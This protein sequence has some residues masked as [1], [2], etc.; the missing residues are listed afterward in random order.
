MAKLGRYSADRKK[1]ETVSAAKTVSVAE[2][3]TIFMLT[4]SAAAAFEIAL[5]TPAAAG[6]GWWCKFIVGTAAAKN[7]TITGAANS[8]NAVELGALSGDAD[9]LANPGNT[10][11]IIGT[12]GVRSANQVGDQVELVTDGTAWYAL[13][14]SPVDDMITISG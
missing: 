14:A 6:A 8:I 13:I 10:I 9:S 11:T 12:D 5:P 1:V 4:M 3:G 7:I 2:C